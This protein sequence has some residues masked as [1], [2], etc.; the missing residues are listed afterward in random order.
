MDLKA[1]KRSALEGLFRRYHK[2]L[3]RYALK[4][5]GD[6]DLAE[7]HIQS[8]FLKIWD[9]K[10]NLGEVKAVKTYLWTALRRSLMASLDEQKKS[11]Q[12]YMNQNEGDPFF[13]SVEEV[14]IK[15]EHKE[16]Q[17]EKLEK[18]IAM[19]SPRQREVVY[20]R[21]YEGMSY[22]EIEEI[23]A[24]NYQVARNYLH[25]GLQRLRETLSSGSQ[26]LLSLLFGILY[27]M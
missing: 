10:A 24:V 5:C 4:F 14:I 18:A 25:K 8:L 1:G 2:D 7:D 19:L 15:N 9:R 11:W 12:R 20:L 26:V 22:Q 21:F 6:R 16:I 13:L 3:F 17:R 27:F 23:M